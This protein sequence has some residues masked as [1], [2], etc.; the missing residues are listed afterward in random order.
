MTGISWAWLL[1]ACAAVYAIKLA[2]LLVPSEVLERPRPLRVATS[3]TV[4]LLA[5]LTTVNTV[6]DGTTLVLDARLLALSAAALALVLRAPFLV[7]V[8][9]GVA[10]AVLARVAGV[11]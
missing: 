7:V 3:V 1:A 6:S 10:V 8:L 2:G 5:A 4:G 11:P 9:V